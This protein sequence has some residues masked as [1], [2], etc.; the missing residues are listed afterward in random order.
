MEST[1]K[2]GSWPYLLSPLPALL[3]FFAFNL[4][5]APGAEGVARFASGFLVLYVA[6]AVIEIMVHAVCH[7]NSWTS[8]R[9]YVLTGGVVGWL[10]IATLFYYVSKLDADGTGSAPEITELWRALLVVTV[11]AVGF[12]IV[13]SL[14]FWAIERPDRPVPADGK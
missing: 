7:H 1:V 5:I 4:I 6:V 14:A 2:K 12:G 13:P 8:W 9:S 3:L 11:G 10:A